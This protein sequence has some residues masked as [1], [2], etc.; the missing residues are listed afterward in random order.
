MANW[1][2]EAFAVKKVK[3]NLPWTYLMEDLNDDGTV[4]LFFK[5]ELQR[6]NQKELKN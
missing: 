4:G 1:S 6:T 5:K 2:E 3:N